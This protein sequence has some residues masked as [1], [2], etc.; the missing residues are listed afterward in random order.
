M[1]KLELNIKP[2]AKQSVRFNKLGFAYQP[3]QVKNKVKEI[4]LLAT[5]EIQRL[6]Q[7]NDY[8]FYTKQLFAKVIYIYKRPKT[9]PKNKIF[10]ENKPDIIDNS[11]KGVFDALQNIVF[12]DDC[13]IVRFEA[14]KVYG[15][16]NQIILFFG[17]TFEYNDIDILKYYIEN[18]KQ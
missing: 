5:N 2:F 3:I 10:K 6:K 8:K 11:N 14:I 15:D 9:I 16:E 1:I 4:A 18:V 7:T 13:L 12:L 17:D